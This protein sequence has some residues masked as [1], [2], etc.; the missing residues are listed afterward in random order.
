V[1]RTMVDAGNVSAADLELFTVTD[2]P[3]ATVETVVACN[4]GACGHEWHRH[5]SA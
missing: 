5:P 4:T 3:Q 2:T 1:G